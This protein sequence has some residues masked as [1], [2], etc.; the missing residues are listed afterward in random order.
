MLSDSL[1]ARSE[2]GS[3]WGALTT[4]PYKLRLIF[5]LALDCAPPPTAPPGYAYAGGPYPPAI[6]WLGPLIF[7]TICL[8]CLITHGSL[9]PISRH[10]TNIIHTK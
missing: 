9:V 7:R 5:S 3:A 2:G 10:F 8:F 6:I 1:G 4:Y